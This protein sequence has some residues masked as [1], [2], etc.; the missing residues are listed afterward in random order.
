MAFSTHQEWVEPKVQDR[1]LSSRSVG[2]LIDSPRVIIFHSDPQSPFTIFDLPL[3][4]RS[5]IHVPDITWEHVFQAVF[6]ILNL[7]IVSTLPSTV[8]GG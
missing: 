1:S 6:S 2:I 4:F 5:S 8:A 7:S 3:T